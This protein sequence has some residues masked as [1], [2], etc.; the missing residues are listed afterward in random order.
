V[1]YSLGPSDLRRITC[2]AV[3][4]VRD[5]VVESRL[6]IE[7]VGLPTQDNLNSSALL[8]PAFL[9]RNSMGEQ[10]RRCGGII[11]DRSERRSCSPM[12]LRSKN[13]GRKSAEELEIVLRRKPDMFNLQPALDYAVS[14]TPDANTLYA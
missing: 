3:R 10:R 9:D 14:D 2:L 7:H 13:A 6:Q 5:G 4:R 8:R 1:K 12:L 11:G